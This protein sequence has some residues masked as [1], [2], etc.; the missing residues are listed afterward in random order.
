M[1]FDMDMDMDMGPPP[2]GQSTKLINHGDP[3]PPYWS[4][5]QNGVQDNYGFGPLPAVD[6]M[7]DDQD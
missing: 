1:T 2:V 5:V 7:N 3:T 4:P 6:G